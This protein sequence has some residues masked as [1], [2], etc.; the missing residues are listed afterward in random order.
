MTVRK[1]KGKAVKK[2]VAIEKAAAYIIIII[3]YL[4]VI[5]SAYNSYRCN[6]SQFTGNDTEEVMIEDWLYSIRDST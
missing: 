2:A 3:R 1:S 6:A 5:L 4:P